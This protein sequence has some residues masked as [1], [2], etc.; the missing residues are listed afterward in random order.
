MT[1]IPTTIPTTIITTIPSSIS[2]TIVIYDEC[3]DEKCLTCSDE[4]NVFGL[5]ITC[6]EAKGYK[7]VNY[8]TVLTEFYDCILNTS[9]K[10]G[11][12]F[13][14]ET[15]QEFRPCYKNCK[16]CLIGGD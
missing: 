13:L 9:T 5:C 15:T 16:K 11:K 14:N 12:Y 4:S 6:N 10:L 2:T 8:T 7:K 1:T 3:E